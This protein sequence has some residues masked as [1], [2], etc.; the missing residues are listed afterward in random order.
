MPPM[1]AGGSMYFR[2]R[3]EL[4][5][6]GKPAAGWRLLGRE[7]GGTTNGRTRSVR[8]RRHVAGRAAPGGLPAGG[9]DWHWQRFARQ[10]ASSRSPRASAPMARCPP[11]QSAC[12]RIPGVGSTWA[13][14][15]SA[16]AHRPTGQNEQAWCQGIRPR[17]GQAR[18][19]RRTSDRRG[20]LTLTEPHTTRPVNTTCGVPSAGA[21]F[22]R[23]L[24]LPP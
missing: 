6:G 12:R 16:S 24:A 22:R 13:P 2:R 17:R 8:H 23:S 5:D 3:S 20:P 21:T 18:P 4:A 19:R 1:I 10:P 7:G 9:R 14:V 11:A 15:A